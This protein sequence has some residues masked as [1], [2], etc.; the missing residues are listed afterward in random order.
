MTRAI[1][2]AAI[3]L[4]LTCFVGVS[5]IRLLAATNTRVMSG[6]NSPRGLAMSPDGSLYVAEAG[7]GG[8]GPCVIAAT[9]EQRC[10][11]LTGAISRLANGIQQRV[12]S[13][14]PSHALPNGDAGAGPNDLSFEGTGGMFVVMGLGF[15]PAAR[16]S[17]GP[18]SERFG[19]LLQ[20]S[21]GGEIREAGDVSAYEDSVNPAR[22][23]V[24]SNPYGLL[25]LPSMRL[26]A[27]AGANA[28]LSVVASGLVNTVAVLPSRPGRSTDSVPTSVVVGPDGAYYVGELS[29]VPFATGAANIYRVVPGRQPQVFQG[30]FTTITDIAF[31]PDGSLYVLEHSTGPAFFGRPGDIVRV[32]PDGTRTIIVS[33]LNRPTS[34][35]VDRDGSVYY[36]NMGITAGAGEV[37]KFTP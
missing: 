6:L 15:D 24:D 25:A 11:G 9:N 36:T 21:A 16:P 2:V 13:G 12:V 18:G 35:L 7:R 29:G 14:L 33:N 5:T 27:D 32:A 30:G 22:G 4:G 26:V 34:V 19:K 28:L 8:S 37:W 23:P 20:I 31:G 3:L 10:F 17:F 1:S